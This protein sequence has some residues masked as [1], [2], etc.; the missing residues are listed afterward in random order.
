MRW[1]DG[2]TKPVDMSLSKLWE[3]VKDTGGL[4]CHSPVRGVPWSVESQR[5]RHDLLTQQQELG[6]KIIS[7]HNSHIYDN[8][9]DEKC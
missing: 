5:V 3:T 9:I 7:S 2:I 8:F 4:A 6:G 1:L